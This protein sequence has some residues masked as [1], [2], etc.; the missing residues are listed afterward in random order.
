MPVAKKVEWVAF[1]ALLL[2]V[3]GTGLWLFT[4]IFLENF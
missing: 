4:L 3:A 2:L 1:L